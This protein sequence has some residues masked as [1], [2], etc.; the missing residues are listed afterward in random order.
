MLVP[1]IRVLVSIQQEDAILVEQDTKILAKSIFREASA[2]TDT[3]LFVH[4]ERINA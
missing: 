2:E 4:K 3:S 1:N